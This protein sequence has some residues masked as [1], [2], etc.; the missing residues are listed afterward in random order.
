MVGGEVVGAEVPA[1]IT[2]VVDVGDS[3]FS[4]APEQAARSVNDNVN[5]RCRSSVFNFHPSIVAMESYDDRNWMVPRLVANL[6]RPI[7]KQRTLFP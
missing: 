4:V 5:N 2:R 7:R 1:S 6:E 3:E